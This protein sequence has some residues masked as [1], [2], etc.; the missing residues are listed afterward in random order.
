MGGQTNAKHEKQIANIYQL[1]FADGGYSVIGFAC[2]I[3][4][5]V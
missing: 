1:P 2:R 3:V 4:V 5:V